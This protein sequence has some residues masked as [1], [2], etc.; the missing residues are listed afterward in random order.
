MKRFYVM[1]AMALLPLTYSCEKGVEQPGALELKASIL[2]LPTKSYLGDEEGGVFPVLWAEGDVISV[3]G[4][5]TNPLTAAAAGVSEA[6]FRVIDASLVAPYHLLYPGEAGVS[7]SVVLDGI[8]PPMYASGSDTGENFTFHQAA[9]GL[10]FSISGELPLASVTLSAPG[11]EKIIGRFGIS[12]TD[13]TLTPS[14]ASSEWGKIY[15]TPADL[16]EP[17]TFTLFIAP[18]SFSEGLVITAENPSGD[19]VTW[20]FAKGRS[21]LAG[22]LYTLPN[23]T[24]SRPFGGW[25]V[26]LEDMTE[27]DVTFEL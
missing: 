2:Q 22:K 23:L 25:Y 14:S 18:G 10:R 16:S 27:D 26:L 12:F 4:T 24:F 20:L 13:G 6:E 11:G 1:L 15:S 9:V 5:L 21:L 8:L 7:N 3:N 17:E 19:S